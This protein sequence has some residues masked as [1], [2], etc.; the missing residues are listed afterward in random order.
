MKWEQLG[1]SRN[2]RCMDA[3]VEDHLCYWLWKENEHIRINDLRQHRSMGPITPDDM[4]FLHKLVC[5]MR[6]RK[7]DRP[8]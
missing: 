8:F 3:C 1:F 7:C 2:V 4:F 6:W 5:E